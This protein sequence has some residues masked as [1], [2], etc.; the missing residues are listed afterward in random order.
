MI[1]SGSTL[2]YNIVKRVVEITQ[3]GK[4]IHANENIEE[5]LRYAA[6]DSKNLYVWKGHEYIPDKH[7]VMGDLSKVKVLMTYRDIRDIV[8]SLSFFQHWKSIDDVIPEIRKRT[9]NREIEL[10]RVFNNPYRVKYEDWYKDIKNQTLLI[11]QFLGLTITNAQAELISNELHIERLKKVTDGQ[12]NLN[13]HTRFGIKHIHDGS[14][15]QWKKKLTTNQVKSIEE[16][17]GDWLLENG[18]ELQTI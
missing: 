11:A 17:C 18:Y 1:R 3:A 4:H 6:T 15:G 5:R 7:I 9:I 10:L 14:V 8:V 16:A 2:Q 13:A 12:N